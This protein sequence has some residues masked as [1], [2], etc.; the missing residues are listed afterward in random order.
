MDVTGWKVRKNL[1]HEAVALLSSPALKRSTSKLV[2]GYGL[3]ALSQCWLFPVTW[4]LNP[5][6]RTIKKW[7]TSFV[8]MGLE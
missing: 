4:N 7:S 3:L 5:L 2:I 1:D 8:I 6:N